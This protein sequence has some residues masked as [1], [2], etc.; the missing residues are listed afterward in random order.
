MTS[1]DST[2]VNFCFI[3]LTPLL[4]LGQKEGLGRIPNIGNVNIVT[5]INL[6]SKKRNRDRKSSEL[7]K[8]LEP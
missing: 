2:A 8:A 4:L 7:V 6:N 5:R 3:P 1:G